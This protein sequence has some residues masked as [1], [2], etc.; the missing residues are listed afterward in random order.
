ME[1][2]GMEIHSSSQ[3]LTRIQEIVTNLLNPNGKYPRIYPSNKIVVKTNRLGG[4]FGAKELRPKFYAGAAAIGCFKT[5][6]PVRLAL[7]REI[8]SIMTGTR[9]PVSAKFRVR[10]KDNGII[11]ELK[12]EYNL[13]I[14]N[15]WDLSLIHI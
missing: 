14:G 11:T 8:D 1:N 2:G 10:G 7:D 9:H 3:F 5:G 4:G 15:S 13:N 6:L 12:Y